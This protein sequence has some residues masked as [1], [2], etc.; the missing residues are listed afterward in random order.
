MRWVGW[1]LLCICFLMAYLLRLSAG[2]LRIPLEADF[3]LSATAFGAMSSMVFYAYTLM[4]IP[5]GVLADSKGV[6]FTVTSGMTVA[7]AGAFIFAMAPAP[8]LLF[9][10]RVLMGMGVAVA[11][12]SS[13]LFM[14]QNFSGGLFGTLSGI[15]S[16][17]GNS[18]GILA[19][20]P[21][22]VMIAALTWRTTFSILGL[23]CFALALG[24]W[25]TIPPGGGGNP[26]SAAAIGRGV[27]SVLG[28]WQ[29]YPVC[30]S[31]TATSACSLALSGTWGVSWV[32]AVLSRG[33]GPFFVSLLAAGTMCGAVAS[34]RLS[35][36]MRSR[37]K[38]LV[39]FAGGQA[40]AWIVLVFAGRLLG[41]LALGA[42]FFF[43][44]FFAGSIVISWAIAKEMNPSCTGLAVAVIN[45]A[46]FFG[47]AVVTSLI[48]VLLDMGAHLPAA[49]A[50]RN[51]FLLPLAAAVAGFVL[52]LIA[53]ETFG[54]WRE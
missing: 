30:A 28:K 15:T 54:G 34:G 39:I 13:V 18:G 8:W 45:T 21:L 29:I 53:P 9:A 31:Y 32:A 2:V 52:S 41:G 36:I 38:P 26:V 37:K 40:L 44:G 1:V 19:Q 46:A 33:D 47:V 25:F 12:I 5:V 6:R 35:D 17:I 50:Y 24:C 14:A 16:F 43:L 27:R 20:A 11:F 42:L 49:E 23:V 7:G 51:A 22:A 48:G 10:G 4:Q 3:S